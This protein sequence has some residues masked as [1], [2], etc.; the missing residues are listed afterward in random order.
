M[1]ALAR[2]RT[3]V[4]RDDVTRAIQEYDRLGPEPF[5]AEH[6][7]GP[8]RSYKLVWE[9]RHYPHKAILGTAYE[10]ATGQR[11]GS[12]EFEGGKSGAVAV[13]RVSR[14]KTRAEKPAS[15]R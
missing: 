1:A 10:L 14:S 8:S 12:A 4:T 3:D 7:F 9:D 13:L 5:F 11:L 6:G 2:L 15:P